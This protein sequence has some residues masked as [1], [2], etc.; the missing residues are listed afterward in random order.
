MDLVKIYELFPTKNDSI[1][2]LERVR[3][4]NKPKCPYCHSANISSLKKEKRYHCNTCNKSFSVTVGTIFQHT[5]LPLQ[6]WFLAISLILKTKK[7]IS[8]RQLAYDI[9]VSQR[10]AYRI[11]MIIRKAMTERE[12]RNFLARIVKIKETYK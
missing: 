8:D 1:A 11:A 7:N 6:K 4:G 5:L 9:Q 12:Q 3:W 2:H 10:T